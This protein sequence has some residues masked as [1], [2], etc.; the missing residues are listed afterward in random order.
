M[1]NNSFQFDATTWNIEN[2]TDLSGAFFQIENF[3]Q[4]LSSWDVAHVTNME[5]MFYQ[6]DFNKDISSWD[7]SNV[8]NMNGMFTGA[9]HFNQDIGSWDVS[10]VTDMSNMF[11]GAFN[12]NQDIGSWDV[13]N[14]TDMSG[15]FNNAYFFNQDI[16]GWNVSSVTDMAG[17]FSNIFY[18]DGD[19]SLWDV[20]N[21]TTMAEM[22]W[23]NSSFN[24][25]ISGWN[26]GSV[27]N[28]S[29]MFMNCSNF[30]QNIGSWDVSSATDMGFMFCSAISFNQDIGSWDIGNVTNTNSMFYNANSF[31]HDISSWDVSSVTDMAG[32]FGNAN[33]FNHDISGWDVSK[34]RS[35][36]D[37]FKN[38]QAFDQNLGD[39]DLSSIINEYDNYS[40][41]SMFE[42]TG[43]SIENYNLT[44]LG[45]ASNDNTPRNV[46]FDGG[47][48][49][50]SGEATAAR[51]YLTDIKNWTITDGGFVGFITE[52]TT[53]NGTISIGDN[54]I[55]EEGVT[56]TIEPGTSLVFK[57][58]YF[59]DVKGRVVAEGTY[60]NRIL[61][62]SDYYDGWRGI[63][64]VENLDEGSIFS[65][66]IFRDVT[67]APVFYLLNGN[68]IDGINI[69][70]VDVIIEDNDNDNEIDG[71]I[72]ISNGN[73][74]IVNSIIANN[75]VGLDGGA[76]YLENS[77][78]KIINCTIVDNVAGGKGGAIALVDSDTDI[79]NTILWHNIANG[80]VNQVNIEGTISPSF[81]NSD[82][83]GGF[84]AITGSGSGANFT[85]D[86]ENNIDAD[87]QFGQSKS[88]NYTVSPSSPIIDSGTLDIEGFQLPDFDIVGNDRIS[89]ELVDMGAFEYA[90]SSV[91]E[92]LTESTELLQNYPNPFNPTTTINYQVVKGGVIN[93]NVYNANGE[94]VKELV[95]SNHKAGHYSIEFDGSNLSSGI[96]YYSIKGGDLRVTKRMV[97]IK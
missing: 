43:L 9:F 83:E 78:S 84:E 87:P 76:I 56:L 12:F 50:Y 16:S 31:T 59:L 5:N 54:I 20:S 29:G 40:M 3:N 61:F 7:V 17:M 47:N 73:I 77:S 80:V 95:K 13:G 68:S 30:N 74:E 90:G 4:D 64:F 41:T 34:V 44:L 89:I 11:E 15:M 49:K 92:N 1:G 96:Y 38:N 70:I 26:V 27:T 79:Y 32:M 69:T 19:I 63:R 45:W 24:K 85:G 23:N 35:M 94:L 82:I 36:G 39:W 28:F 60:N 48:S 72:H 58:D 14:V 51:S 55:I 65:N 66:C 6:T 18:F 88:Y 8:E 57:G 33:S 81:Y 91:D 37:M 71:T 10:S 53:W 21:V 22:F 86:Y 62:T 42:N 75:S 52:D 67:N 93:L 46:K 2:I 25:D 97:L